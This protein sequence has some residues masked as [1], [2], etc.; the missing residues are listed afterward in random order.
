MKP[1]HLRHL[2]EGER[3]LAREVFGDGIR[4]QRVRLLSLPWWG[5]AFVPGAGLIVW[6]AAEAMDDFSAAPLHVQAALVHELVHVWQAQHGTWLPWAKIRAGDKA[7]S[8]AYDLD[9]Q[10]DFAALNIEQ[11]AMVIEDAF[12]ASRGGSAPYPAE[13]YAE[14]SAAWRRT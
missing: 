14:A 7:G 2:T 10:P 4:L 12:A 5:R 3:A 9:R 1:L 13:R 6:P 11:Q 8:Y